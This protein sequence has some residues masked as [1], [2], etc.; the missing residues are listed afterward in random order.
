MMQKTIGK[1]IHWTYTG[2][3]FLLPY[4]FIVPLN[5]SFMVPKEALLAISA[6]AV[7]I[8]FIFWAISR[9]NT[10]ILFRREQ[11]YLTLFVVYMGV[12]CFFSSSFFSAVE[13]FLPFLSGYILLNVFLVFYRNGDK[14]NNLQF[15]LI[16]ALVLAASL[17]AFLAIMQYLGIMN[18]FFQNAHGKWR[19]FGT[20]GNPN[21]IAEFLLPVFFINLNLLHHEPRPNY[22]RY[23]S[24]TLVTIVVGIFSTV[25]RSGILLLFGGSMLYLFFYIRVTG[26]NLKRF[27]VLLVNRASRAIS[28]IVIA[29]VLIL[30]V[31]PL[32]RAD[33]TLI[34]H[35]TNKDSV[36]GRLF[37][38]QNSV[39]S[40]VDHFP[41]G[42]GI[43]GFRKAYS[44]AQYS[45]FKNGN[46]DFLENSW[47][48]ARAHNDLLQFFAETGVW[49][50]FLLLF[51]FLVAKH[52]GTNLASDNF[53]IGIFVAFL[54]MLGSSMVNFPLRVAP[55]LYIF[56]ILTALVILHRSCNTTL[57][58]KFNVAGAKARWLLT[59]IIPLVLLIIF[60]LRFLQSSYYLQQGKEAEYKKDYRA[61]EFYYRES[62]DIHPGNSEAAYLQSKQLIRRGKY[63]QAEKLLIEGLKSYP[64][65]L[66]YKLLAEARNKLK[67]RAGS[68]AALDRL[69]YTYRKII[70][71]TARYIDCLFINKQ[72][73]RIGYETTELNKVAAKSGKLSPGWQSALMRANSRYLTALTAQKVQIKHSGK[74]DSF[75]FIVQRTNGML[76][77][78]SEGNGVLEYHPVYKKF[79]SLVDKQFSFVYSLLIN[80][81]KLWAGTE[82]G[83][84]VY[85]FQNKKWKK[86]DPVKTHLG[87][88][89]SLMKHGDSL[90]F[91]T[92]LLVGNY[93]FK[94]KLIT[95][96][97]HAGGVPLLGL[98][99]ISKYKKRLYFAGRGL[100]LSWNKQTGFTT[101]NIKVI[102]VRTR[103]YVAP[104]I[105]AVHPFGRELVGLCSDQGLITYFIPGKKVVKRDY[106]RQSFLDMNMLDTAMVLLEVNGR[107]TT[108]DLRSHFIQ[109]NKD[110][111]SR[112]S[113]GFTE[114]L[115]KRN[116]NNL[117]PNLKANLTSTRLLIYSHGYFR[118]WIFGATPYGLLS[119]GGLVGSVKF[120]QPKGA[121]PG[122]FIT[123]LLQTDT[124]VYCA[125]ENGIWRYSGNSWKFLER[126]SGNFLSF[127]KFNN[128][129]YFADKNVIKMVRYPFPA[130]LVSVYPEQLRAFAVGNG[131]RVAAGVSGQLYIHGPRNIQIKQKMEDAVTDIV[132]YKNDCYLATVDKGV[133]VLSLGLKPKVYKTINTLSGLPDQGVSTLKLLDDSIWIGTR[134]G[135]TV[136]Y[137][138]LSG[139]LDIMKDFNDHD[140]SAITGVF[141]W[142]DGLFA[143]T[144]TD[145]LMITGNNANYPLHF[146]FPPEWPQ[147][148][149]G[150]V[151]HGEDLIVAGAGGIYVYRKFQTVLQPFMEYLT[152][153]SSTGKGAVQ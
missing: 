48:V 49:V 14:H 139:S 111:L 120:E 77:L 56:F 138:P 22:R 58:L 35:V 21:Y 117:V 88:I 104:D 140:N 148:L 70:P 57:L 38:W 13:Q 101:H 131:W 94:Y 20:M 107:I 122:H 106:Y 152:G 128:R 105:R 26:V 50:A 4:I 126:T 134:R 78:A 10:E 118:N 146:S 25:S 141:E 41:F 17:E 97:E 121:Q 150:A 91:T 85:S 46:L 129:V 132:I 79:R 67:N 115:L 27:L 19:V 73:S 95:L 100:L 40:A 142:S 133:H 103:K 33:R 153:R 1:M 108:K 32:L 119:K 83:L 81:N 116:Y 99:S 51:L 76:Y 84:F 54:T 3:I 96:Y 55:N 86:F 43:G 2:L 149:T 123:D 89:T 90:W 72:W 145:E 6:L 151:M 68:I 8:L 136:V 110:D 7:G 12:S 42:T 127:Q 87:R 24:I 144:T 62:F 63:R 65:P 9:E 113:V 102:D 64:I 109:I 45:H 36:T 59:V 114:N 130:A 60:P 37:I 125:D 28:L 135:G 124:G 31:L 53:S 93:N 44:D 18:A 66:A 80:D 29:F 112:A 39:K 15:E 16:Q 52:G 5:S 75:T 11:L 71:Y 92:P 47:I 30:F 98:Q 143:L 34:N 69:A 147:V 23:Y 137:D 61:A 82:Q 74:S